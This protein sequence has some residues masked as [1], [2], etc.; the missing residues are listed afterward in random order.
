M[1]PIVVAAGIVAA[2][3]VAGG[4]I[5]SAGQA[6]A[7][8]ENAQ[9]AS[10]ATNTNVAEAQKNRDFQERMSNTAYQRGVKDMTAAGINP[11]LA[12]DRGGAS[13]PSGSTAQAVT[14]TMQN[15][16]SPLGSGISQAA[17]VPLAAIQ[18]QANVSLANAQAVQ[19]NSQ[20]ALNKALAEKALADAGYSN[21]SARGAMVD[22]D[23]A[24]A[25]AARR[26]SGWGRFVEG[27]GD[28]FGAIGKVFSGSVRR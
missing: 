13:T 8:E 18:T 4:A 10:D 15:E 21:A 22:A 17:Q 5:S 14:A 26:T 23:I 20:T 25:N 19:S 27:A 16:L 1:P 11:I 28:I 2:G 3:A 12:A 7:N 24:E 9:I 6:D